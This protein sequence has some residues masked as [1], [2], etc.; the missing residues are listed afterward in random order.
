M[1]ENPDVLEKMQKE[2]DGVIGTERLPGPADV[3][4]LPY[5]QAV[6]QEVRSL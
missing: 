3:D 2:M 6:L 5:M 4:R 1:A